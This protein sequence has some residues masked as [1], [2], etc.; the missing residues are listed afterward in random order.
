MGQFILVVPVFLANMKL[1]AYLY[2]H[3]LFKKTLDSM[4][5]EKQNISKMILVLLSVCTKQKKFSFGIQKNFQYDQ[6]FYTCNV[7]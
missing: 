2:G 6:C 3:C 4:Q 5:N 7:L 1:V